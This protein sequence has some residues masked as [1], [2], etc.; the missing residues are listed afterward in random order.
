[1]SEASKITY[2]EGTFSLRISS[3]PV[4]PED[5]QR[6]QKGLRETMHTALHGRADVSGDHDIDVGMIRIESVEEHWDLEDSGL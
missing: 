2:A 4:T 3:Q 1:M 6:L 5:I